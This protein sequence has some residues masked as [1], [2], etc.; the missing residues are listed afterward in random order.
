MGC[1]LFRQCSGKLLVRG[2]VPNQRP[3]VVPPDREQAGEKLSFGRE[4]G[5]RAV[6]PSRGDA[7]PYFSF[8]TCVTPWLTQTP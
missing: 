1:A 7:T 3:Q 6:A 4:A 5:P 8:V 2:A